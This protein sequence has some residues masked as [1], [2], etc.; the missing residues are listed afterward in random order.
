[1]MLRMMGSLARERGTGWDACGNCKKHLVTYHS[2]NVGAPTPPDDHNATSTDVGDASAAAECNDCLPASL[3]TLRRCGGC[4]LKWYCSKDCQRANWREHKVYCKELSALSPQADLQFGRGFALMD[5]CYEHA[6]DIA[7]AATSAVRFMEPPADEHQVLLLYVAVLP[8]PDKAAK[9]GARF[10]H[11]VDDAR[12]VPFSSMEMFLS[13]MATSH[14]AFATTPKLRDAYITK[15]VNELAQVPGAVTVSALAIDIDGSFPD[16][17][18]AI[19][20]PVAKDSALQKEWLA[21]LV[22]AVN[23]KLHDYVA[24]LKI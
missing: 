9:C 13:D 22:E 3:T 6:R 21:G 4:K 5:W 11:K 16:C 14:N 7:I 24:F 10:L 8:L 18:Y 15:H 12:A 20:Q 19:R 23:P 1:M 2:A 17:V